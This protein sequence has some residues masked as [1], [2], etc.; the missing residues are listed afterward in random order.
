MIKPG[1]LFG[2]LNKPLFKIGKGKISKPLCEYRHICAAG[3]IAGYK[4]FF[5]ADINIEKTIFCKIG[6]AEAALTQ[7][8]FYD[9]FIVE[10]EVNG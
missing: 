6:N 1:K 9:V 5:D 10:L 2:L 7:H 8:F 3:A 4:Q